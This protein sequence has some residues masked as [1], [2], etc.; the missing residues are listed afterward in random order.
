MSKKILTND[1]RLV[2]AYE[3]VRKDLEAYNVSNCISVNCA[4]K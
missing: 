2:D 3:R 1:E 4:E